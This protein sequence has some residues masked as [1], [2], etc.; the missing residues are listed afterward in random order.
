MASTIKE[1]TYRELFNDIINGKFSDSEIINEKELVE[2]YG[3]SKTSIREVL[4]ML[5]K[6]GILKNIPRYGY[7]IVR[8]TERDIKAVDEYRVILECNC[9]DRYW[10]MLNKEKIAEFR[11]FYNSTYGDYKEYDTTT[12]W[13]RNLE[14]HLKLVSFY[15]NNYIYKALENALSIQHRAYAQF[16]LE[17]WQSSKNLLFPHLHEKLLIAIENQD[18]YLALQLMQEDIIGFDEKVQFDE[19]IKSKSFT[20]F[21]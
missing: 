11:D 16:Y 14:Y 21:M 12:H 13:R 20:H 8:Y 4:V 17:K 1:K 2:R 19:Y 15:E 5:C 18:K 3:V 7:Q 10:T 6:D 9:L